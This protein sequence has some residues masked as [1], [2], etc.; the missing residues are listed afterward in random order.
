MNANDTRYAEIV[1]ACRE[2]MASW[3]ILESKW[4][5]GHEETEYV[6]GVRHGFKNAARMI[7]DELMKADAK[8]QTVNQPD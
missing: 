8:P 6:R 1:S 5:A 7:E 2:I 3:G 4:K